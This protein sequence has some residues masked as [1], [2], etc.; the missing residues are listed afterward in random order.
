MQI[1]IVPYRPRKEISHGVPLP[2]RVTGALLFS[3][4]ETFASL[5]VKHEEVKSKLS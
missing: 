4:H 5:Q 1:P 3:F 2:Q